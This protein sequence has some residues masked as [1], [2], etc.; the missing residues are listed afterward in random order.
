MTLV[1]LIIAAGMWSLGVREW[2]DTGAGD[3]WPL[4]FLAGLL[5]IGAIIWAT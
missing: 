4:L 2:R 3:A 1:T 5:T